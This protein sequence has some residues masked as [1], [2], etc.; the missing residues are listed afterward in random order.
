MRKK[1]F[2]S[3]HAHFFGALTLKN[4]CSRQKPYGLQKCNCVAD[5]FCVLKKKW[6]TYREDEKT[7]NTDHKFKFLEN[8]KTYHPHTS[9]NNRSHLVHKHRTFLTWRSIPTHLLSK[10]SSR[11][12]IPPHLFPTQTTFLHKNNVP[13]YTIEKKK[14]TSTHT[15]ISTY[16]NTTQ[17]I[18]LTYKIKNTHHWTCHETKSLVKSS[19]THHEKNIECTTIPQKQNKNDSKK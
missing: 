6:S 5:V 7:K 19:L 9:R 15:H 18:S 1:T 2:L 13:T 17:S 14:H 10:H 16:Q 12:I 11:K 4:I 3:F 8:T